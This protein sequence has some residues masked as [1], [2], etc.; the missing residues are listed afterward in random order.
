[1]ALT[2]LCIQKAAQAWCKP[3]TEKTD[4]DTDLCQAFAEILEEIWGQAW[5]GNATTRQLLDELSARAEVDGALD[6]K[7]VDDPFNVVGD[8]D[9][10][11]H[12][13]LQGEV[14]FLEE[15]GEE[16]EENVYEDPIREE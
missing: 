13:A 2:D 9:L 15:I 14:E 7:P 10:L 16:D 12:A 4:M 1:M 8:E 6:Y 3:A 5:L 11:V